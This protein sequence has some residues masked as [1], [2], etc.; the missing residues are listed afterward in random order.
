MEELELWRKVP[1][2]AVWIFN[3][4]GDYLFS[5]YDSNI[6]SYADQPQEEF[7][8]QVVTFGPVSKTVKGGRRRSFRALVVVGNGKGKVGAGMGKAQD[9]TDAI[10]KG[11]EDAKKNLIEV[12]MNGTTIPHEVMG[13]FGAG[14]VLLKPASPGTGIIAGRGVRPV[15][16]LAGIEDVLT[17]SL[18][19]SN[20][21]NVVYA[22]IEALKNLRS[23][24]EIAELRGLTRRREK[25]EESEVV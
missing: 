2:R 19:S 21:Y 16:E 14:K 17:K 1:E 3:M 13:E 15:M 22:T 11:I 8:D 18:G 4:W 23:A 6:D 20:P 24:R 9:L 10:R 7:K 12:P 5:A 25:G